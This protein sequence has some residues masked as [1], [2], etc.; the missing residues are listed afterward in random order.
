MLG[1]TVQSTSTGQNPPQYL[2]PKSCAQRKLGPKG[3]VP[4]PP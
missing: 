2:W 3:P 1:E 4:N